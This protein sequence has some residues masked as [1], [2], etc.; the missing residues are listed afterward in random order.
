ML[1]YM[2]HHVLPWISAFE[3]LW[4]VFLWP[5]CVDIVHTLPCTTPHFLF[6]T[7]LQPKDRKQ[8]WAL[9]ESCPWYC[10][11]EA[12]LVIRSLH[13]DS[14]NYNLVVPGSHLTMIL[15]LLLWKNLL[16]FH[17]STLAVWMYLSSYRPF[18]FNF[19]SSCGIFFLGSNTRTSHDNC[20][21]WILPIAVGSTQLTSLNPILFFQWLTNWS[22]SLP[23]KEVSFDDPLPWGP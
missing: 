20:F 23:W 11:T 14:T 4:P 16:V 18:Y 12:A 3:K 7:I 9:L 21:T 19:S 15:L 13:A 17:L 8:T 6:F 1:E 10:V 2:V 22:R 5:C